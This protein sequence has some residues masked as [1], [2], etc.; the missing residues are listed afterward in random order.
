[1]K[2]R[3]LASLL[4]GVVLSAATS[5]ASASVW[6][7]E[8]HADNVGANDH[9][10]FVEIA[11]TAGTP[12]SAY[13]IVLYNS[14]TGAPYGSFS[15]TDLALPDSQNG[16]GVAAVSIGGFK[17]DIADGI[18]LV[19]DGTTVIQLLSYG[20]TF[21]RTDA[22]GGVLTSTDVG[23]SAHPNSA[24]LVGAGR[25]YSD[26]TW[27]AS[28]D[29]ERSVTFLEV[30]PPEVVAAINFGQEFTAAAVIPEPQTYA[31]LLAG[32]G[33]LGFAARRRAQEAKRA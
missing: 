28:G 1:M 21:T 24:H 8:F 15:F 5:F 3:P 26:F 18:A 9:E 16:I 20:I 14:A 2:T 25:A 32:L 23:F 33:L 27:E 6:I 22:L 10:E 12:L 30:F 29:G 19:Q 7:N 4:A 17:D 13:S 11:G 31:L